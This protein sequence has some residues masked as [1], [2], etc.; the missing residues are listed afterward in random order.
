MASYVEQDLDSL[1]N[2]GGIMSDIWLIRYRAV[3]PRYSLIVT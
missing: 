2:T 1:L 3:K